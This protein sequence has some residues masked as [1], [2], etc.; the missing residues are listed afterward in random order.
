MAVIRAI[1]YVEVDDSAV[2]KIRGYFEN[3]IEYIVDMETNSEI[4]QIYGV[5]TEVVK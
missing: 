3:H 1:M 4:E 5:D 2:E